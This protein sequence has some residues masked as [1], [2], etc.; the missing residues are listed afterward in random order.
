[1]PYDDLRAYLD[2]LD[3]EQ[4]LLH[5]TDE[6][7]PECDLEAAT[8]AAAALGDRA[9]G[10]YFDNL[11]GLGDAQLA[12]GLHRSWANHAVALGLP[13]TTPV[14][15]QVAEFTR[16][17]ESAPVPV[18][19]RADP[20]WD[21]YT[22]AGPEVDL[23][24]VLPLL[25]L[26][27][28]PST[29]RAFVTVDGTRLSLARF[30]VRSRNRLSLDR[31]VHGSDGH[32]SDVPVAITLGNDPMVTVAAACDQGYELAGA[33]RGAPCPVAA[34]P[35]TGLDVPW[36]SEIVLEGVIEAR[37]GGSRSPAVR[38]DRISHRAGPITESL[39]IGPPGT[40]L[41]HLTGP[42][43]C[44][45]LGR[46]LRAEFPEVRAVNALYG[47]GR[48]AVVAVARRHQTLPKEVAARVTGHGLV[49]VVDETVDP[50]DLPQVMRAL[51][52]DAEHVVVDATTPASRPPDTADWA[53]RL[54]DLLA[55]TRAHA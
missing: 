46:Q 28:V 11:R 19:R 44:G 31:P 55:R 51:A 23:G 9:P 35:L 32:S 39:R 43:A 1:M 36:G 47:E 7:D 50:F 4:Q 45:R 30:T 48:L 17:W 6:I 27:E 18:E 34:A 26:D 16:R 52:T 3:L 29:E 42:A 49:I 14:R 15:S 37:A 54:H 41:G 53:G 10:L 24:L 33:L 38:V 40:E 5:V 2:V 22:S 13:A 8:A 25:R 20:P 21:D 12:V